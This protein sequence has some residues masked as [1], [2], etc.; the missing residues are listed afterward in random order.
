MK[1]N[2]Q[3]KKIINGKNYDTET[4]KLIG[5]Y[6]NGYGRG[7]FSY[8]SEELYLKKTGEFFLYAEG[9]ALTS[10]SVSVANG[11]TMGEHIIPYS[12]D[13]AIEW[14]ERHCDAETYEELFGDVEE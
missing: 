6:W 4:A 13:E 7:D 3:M 1:G 12:K 10:Y 5:E 8:L 11:S 14:I 9:G 2:K